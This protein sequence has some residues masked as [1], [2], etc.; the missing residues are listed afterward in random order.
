MKVYEHAQHALLSV[1]NDGLSFQIAINQTLKQEKKKIDRDF[2]GTVSALVGC[3]LR[4]F[5][6]F[7]KLIKD[8]FE[9]IDNN[10]ISLLM[11]ALSN[12]LFVKKID[13]AEMEE[14]VEKE[15]SYEQTK[16]FL[17]ENSDV[18]KLIP[19]SIPSDSKT[20]VQLRYN[21]PL[22]IVHMWAK[23]NGP[24]LS[25]RLYFSFGQNPSRLVRINT[26]KISSE[27]FFEKYQ[28]FQKVE[29]DNLALNS[30]KEN[31]KANPA[32][33]NMDAF[34]MPCAYTY[35][36]KDL[37]LDPIRGIALFAECDNHLLDELYLLLGP[38]FQ[39]E[40]ICGD[41][42]TYFSMNEKVK[43]YGLTNAALFETKSIITCISKPVHT[44]FVCPKNSHLAALKEYPDYFLN[45]KQEDLDTFI[46]EESKALEEA[47]PLVES[48]GDLIYFV[49]TICKNESSTIIHKFLEKHKEYRLMEQ[50]QLF[51]FDKYKSFLYFAI[52]RK[53]V[54]ND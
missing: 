44:F 30:N 13:E 15:C 49:P 6:I 38:N 4:H 39:F 1:L 26:Q 36:C 3:S 23:N 42:K 48:G 32:I 8:Y 10:D 7:E 54:S 20:Y 43:R 40:Y 47:A 24:V 21:I 53:E 28:D 17:D 12:K 45:I 18:R 35:M 29:E 52:L 16:D 5:Y 19:E 46:A 41:Q 50:K 25:K 22:W 37:D 11:I 34:N 27:A 14:Y 33:R 51:P 2:K 9:D 31:I